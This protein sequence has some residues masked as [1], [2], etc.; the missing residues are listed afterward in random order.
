MELEQN[1]DFVEVAHDVTMEI[2][3]SCCND[4]YATDL[5]YLVSN[6]VVLPLRLLSIHKF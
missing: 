6:S 3:I 4:R 5:V 1:G 2:D